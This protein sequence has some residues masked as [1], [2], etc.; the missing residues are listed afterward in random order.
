MLK[1]QKSL[2][3]V[4]P[5]FAQ[6]HALPLLAEALQPC[7]TSEK[8]F[9]EKP[10]HSCGWE[11]HLKQDHPEAKPTPLPLVPDHC[12]PSLFALPRKICQQVSAAKL[13]TRSLPLSHW[14]QTAPIHSGCLIFPQHCKMQSRSI[15]NSPAQPCAATAPSLSVAVL[16][17]MRNPHPLCK[18]VPHLFPRLCRRVSGVA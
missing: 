4:D 9:Q 16:A 5:C 6:C 14:L 7:S 10:A 1:C 18:Q 15:H 13:L 11:Q 8:H 12:F 17:R 3:I 2:Q